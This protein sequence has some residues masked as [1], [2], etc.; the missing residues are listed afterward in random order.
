VSFVLYLLTVSLLYTFCQSTPKLEKEWIR[1]KNILK[2]L[3]KDPFSMVM[4]TLAPVIIFYLVLCLSPTSFAIENGSL[5]PSVFNREI[6][7]FDSMSWI[8]SKVGYWQ[9]LW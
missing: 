3:G 2:N 6:L 8:G 9:W 7:N 1:L 4:G 5:S